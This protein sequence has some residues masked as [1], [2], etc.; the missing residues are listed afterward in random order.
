MAKSKNNKASSRAKTKRA[1]KPA[2]K[3]EGPGRNSEAGGKSQACEAHCL[4]AESRVQAEIGQ[5]RRQNLGEAGAQG[6]QSRQA[7]G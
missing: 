4:Q 7:E 2:A 5:G 1:V 3:A 6:G